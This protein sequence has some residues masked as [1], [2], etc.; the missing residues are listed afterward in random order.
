L[1]NECNGFLY[2]LNIPLCYLQMSSDQVVIAVLERQFR[3]LDTSLSER[4]ASRSF[5]S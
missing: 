2:L 1:S 4:Q 5:S 3:F